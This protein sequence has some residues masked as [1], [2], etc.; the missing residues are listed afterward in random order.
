MCMCV[1]VCVFVCVCFCVSVSVCVCSCVCVLLCVRK[2]FLMECLNLGFHYN[3]HYRKLQISEYEWNSFGSAIPQCASH[4]DLREYGVLLY[5]CGSAELGVQVCVCV[6]AFVCVCVCL[7][8]CVCACVCVY[9][10]IYMPVCVC[11]HV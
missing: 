1:F 2:E 4:I 7:C 9:M 10:C 11:V 3:S 6:C 5:Y 8:V